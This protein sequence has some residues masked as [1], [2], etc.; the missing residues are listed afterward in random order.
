M[1]GVLGAAIEF[2]LDMGIEMAWWVYI[3]QLD[4]DI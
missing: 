4:R 3:L 1:S 2:C